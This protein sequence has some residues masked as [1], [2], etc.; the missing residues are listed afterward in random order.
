MRRT[1]AANIGDF[2]KSCHVRAR[3]ANHAGHQA[4]QDESLHDLERLDMLAEGLAKW[5]AI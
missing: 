4:E 2:S 3:W 5:Q 1:L